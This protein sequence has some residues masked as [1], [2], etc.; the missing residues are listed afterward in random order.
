MPSEPGPGRN[1]SLAG[2]QCRHA[3]SVSTASLDFDELLRLPSVTLCE[4]Q[5][6][7]SIQSP[8]E[9]TDGPDDLGALGRSR[10]RGGREG[11]LCFH[12]PP[13]SAQ[14]PG[15]KQLVR[16]GQQ[17]KMGSFPRAAHP[18]SGTLSADCHTLGLLRAVPSQKPQN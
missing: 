7:L 17:M 3:A 10:A 9:G 6:P 18:S 2:L 13:E 4:A 14:Q 11:L 16:P 1:L 5:S 15:V 12:L 8:G